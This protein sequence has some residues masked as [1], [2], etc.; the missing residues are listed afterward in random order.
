MAKELSKKKKFSWSYAVA[1]I[2]AT[3]SI[4]KFFGSYHYFQAGEELRAWIMITLY[5]GIFFFSM[6]FMAYRI[7][8][9]EKKKDNLRSS[10]F[11]FDWLES[12][13]E[14]FKKGIQAS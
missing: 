3:I 4:T 7:Y 11:F 14:M 5:L 10:F 12:K 9:E 13:L 8:T 6:G 1:F 2:A